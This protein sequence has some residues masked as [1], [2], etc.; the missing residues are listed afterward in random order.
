MKYTYLFAVI[1]FLFSSPVIGQKILTTDSGQRILLVDDGS[2]RI[3][4]ESESVDGE[5]SGSG[6]SLESFKSPKQGKYP[7]TADE[8]ENI[9]NL[10]TNFLSDEAQLIVN[11]EMAKRKLRQ[12]KEEKSLAKK[13]KESSEKI[14]TQITQTKESIEND[15]KFYKTTS[16]LIELSNELL[17]GKIKNK[18]KAFAALG[19]DMQSIKSINSGMGGAST[20][21][22]KEET[23]DLIAEPKAVAIKYPTSFSI[24]DDAQSDNLDCEIVFDGYDDE[25]GSDRKEVKSAPFFSYSQEKMKPYFK[26]EDYL[27]C[28]GNISKVGKDYYL[29]L[30]IRIRSKDANKTYG[31]MRSDEN[32]KIQLI[33]GRSVYGKSINNDSG[34]IE[35]YTGHTLYTGIFQLNKGDIN[36]LKNNFL[37]NIG[38]IWSSGYEEYNIFNV[39]FLINQIE[40]LNK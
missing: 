38:I 16:E 12:L 37:D 25:I 26:T 40:C 13:E 32:L 30:K 23:Q 27:N 15:E 24:E 39:D 11:I 29:T 14:K 18:E 2:W 31:M 34:Q 7:V 19:T 22:L 17:E 33:N 4:D 36:Q 5:S 1:A 21:D 28:E 10:L 35:S 3:V 20:D 9:Q 6:T 8:R